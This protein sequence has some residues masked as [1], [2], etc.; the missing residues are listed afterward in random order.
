MIVSSQATS[1]SFFF[2]PKDELL[3]ICYMNCLSIAAYTY[4]PTSYSHRNS[5][6]LVRNSIDTSKSESGVSQLVLSSHISMFVALARTGAPVWFFK[7]VIRH[8]VFLFSCL[9]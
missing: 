8:A 5:S 6:L 4:R 2:L 9:A 1:L 3:S 7:R